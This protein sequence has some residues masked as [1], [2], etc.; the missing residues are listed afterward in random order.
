MDSQIKL[1]RKAIDKVKSDETLSDLEKSEKI[2]RL[3]EVIVTPEYMML[4][5]GYIVDSIEKKELA[6]EFFTYID[7]AGISQ[8]AEGGGT[9]NSFAEWKKQFGLN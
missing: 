8:M 3:G 1:I 2:K 4:K 9:K 5:L 6:T 7:M